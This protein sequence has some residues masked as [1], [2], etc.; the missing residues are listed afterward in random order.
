MS[1]DQYK[2]LYFNKTGFNVIVVNDKTKIP[3]RF[4]TT[5]SNGF[6]EASTDIYNNLLLK[7]KDSDVTFVIDDTEVP[8][9]R[10]ILSKH[11]EY[12]NAMFSNNFIE[13]RSDKVILK[14]TNLKAF[15]QVLAYIYTNE[16]QHE[17]KNTIPLDE[18]FEV[19]ACA[20]FYMISLTLED[21]SY[22]ET[23]GKDT[24]WLLLNNA[25]D[26]SID[27]LIP[28]SV[29]LIQK[30]VSDN[31]KM[32]AF[33]KLSLPALEHVLKVGL[34]T[35][36]SNVFEALVGWMR[37]NPDC[38]SSF[39][40]L[41]KHITLYLLEEDHLNVLLKPTPL[42]SRECIVDLLSEQLL[43][44]QRYKKV[45]NQNVIA[46]VRIVEGTLDCRSNSMTPSSNGAIIFDLKQNY[47]L[48]CLK[49]GNIITHRCY[50]SQTFTTSSKR[51]C[52]YFY[53]VTT[54]IDM[55]DWKYL[56]KGGYDLKVFKFEDRIFRFIRINFFNG[57]KF[58]I[59]AIIEAFYLTK[60]DRSFA[61]TIGA[62]QMLESM[63]VSGW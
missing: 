39:P 55:R 37:Q 61:D 29:D 42:V 48:N 45:E 30:N 23:G 16:M 58:T 5:V 53:R 52:R 31:I 24:L 33:K 44:S 21:I 49:L 28:F 59:G 62:Q 47:L 12:F 25:I 54:S 60:S 15:K 40:E 63:I 35:Q 4:K 19:F 1:A 8:A 6:V 32:P 7:M 41:L 13:S 27:E 11:S 43:K 38:S 57:C 34:D 18:I 36:E 50:S 3:P 56:D 22:L 17:Y 14:E 20:Q 51:R 46:N 9:L 26:Y 10:A 2:D